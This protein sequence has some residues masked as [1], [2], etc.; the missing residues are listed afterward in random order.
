MEACLCIC[1]LISPLGIN[2]FSFASRKTFFIRV[3]PSCPMRALYLALVF[4]AA[5][6]FPSPFFPLVF[7]WTSYFFRIPFVCSFKSQAGLK[8]RHL[9]STH[10]FLAK[11]NHISCLF[12][13]YYIFSNHSDTLLFLDSLVLLLFC[14]LPPTVDMFWFFYTSNLLN[15]VTSQ[16]LVGFLFT[17]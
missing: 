13:C 2:I 15:S 1:S 10:M 17:M 12:F 14:R 3:L 7:L 4:L 5:T 9:I 8:V 11:N 6:S 16:I